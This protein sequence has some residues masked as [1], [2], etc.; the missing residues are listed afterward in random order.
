MVAK[1]FSSLDVQSNGRVRLTVGVGGDYPR[2]FAAC[3]V[4]VSERGQ[5]TQEAI[6]IMRKYWSGQRFDY[7]GKIFK[8]KDV[9]MLPRPLNGTIPIWVSGRQEAPLKRAA[10]L[11]DGWHPYMYTPERCRE[12]FHQV[13]KFASEGGRTLPKDYVFACFIYVA[14]YDDVEEARNLGIKEL[15]YRYDQDFSER[16]LVDRY[17]AYGPPEKV[18]EYL[19]KYVEAGTNY[20]I[21]APIMPPER[22]VEHLERIAKEVVPALN[23]ISP[24][25]IV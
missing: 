13:V 17:C 4:P 11:G 10:L 19:S 7:D 2:E 24:R 8:L 15:S 20:L 16:G 14:L 5:R 23:K 9:D 6:E 12:S 3:D 18:I 25:S 21:L 22:R 1:Q